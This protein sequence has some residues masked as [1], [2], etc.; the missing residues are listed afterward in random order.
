MISTD[1]DEIPE[2]FWDASSDT[3]TSITHQTA[4]KTESS[5]DTENEKITITVSVN[6]SENQWIYIE[7]TDDYPEYELTVK[8]SDGRTIESDKIYRKNGKIYV[9]DDPD[10]EYEFS[11]EYTILEPTFNPAKGT[12]FSASDLTITITYN[13]IV[14]IQSSTLNGVAITL[15][16]ADNLVFVYSAEGLENGDYA[17]SVTAKD[18]ENNTRTDVAAYTV[19][20]QIP[21]KTTPSQEMP[22]IFVIIA[23]IAVFWLIIGIMFK[24][25]FLYLDKKPPKK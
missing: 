6:K 3:I 5:I 13:E 14:T 23:I 10:T 12:S 20:V 7:T 17:L 21:D 15:E 2:F 19:S 16:T 9:L 11:Y 22:W 25:G 24:T 8:T 4:T 18:N 1:D